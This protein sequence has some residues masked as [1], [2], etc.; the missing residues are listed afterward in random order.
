MLQSVCFEVLL[1]MEA[2][3]NNRGLRVLA[4]WSR[5]NIYMRLETFGLWKKNPCHEINVLYSN[6]KHVVEVDLFCLKKRRSDTQKWNSWGSNGL[7][8][9][10]FFRNW[11]GHFL[12]ID[13]CWRNPSA[14][15]FPSKAF[16]DFAVHEYIIKTNFN[17]VLM[18][19]WEKC[20]S[21]A[22]DEDP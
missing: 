18:T 16:T 7:K 8:R 20:N 21:E 9:V 12:K 15:A 3:R 11:R 10:I 5:Q 17:L 6:I 22:L 13:V 4:N 2:F 19:N 1:L 14:R